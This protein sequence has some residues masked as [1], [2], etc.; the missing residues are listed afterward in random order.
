MQSTSASKVTT[1]ATASSRIELIYRPGYR[2]AQ[3]RLVF[4]VPWPRDSKRPQDILAY[5]EWFTLTR[6]SPEASTNMYIVRRS[7]S[8][9]G[10]RLHAILPLSRIARPVNLVPKRDPSTPC[11]GGIADMLDALPDDQ[12]YY[13]NSFYD[14]EHFKVVY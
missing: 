2:I 1:K 13:V 4:S 3:V 12:E 6:P 11:T 9:D 5:V 10:R 7:L 8:R 14:K